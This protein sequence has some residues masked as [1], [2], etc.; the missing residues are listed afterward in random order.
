MNCPNCKEA[1]KKN[2]KDRTGEQKYKCLTCGSGFTTKPKLE[3]KRVPAAKIEMAIN[4]LV[5]GCSVRSV[6]RLTSIHRDTILRLL[7]TVGERCMMLQEKLVRNVVM[8]NLEMDEIW[9]YCLMKQKTA[10]AKGLEDNPEIGSVYTFTAIDRTSKLILAW[11]CGKRGETD[12]LT[13]LHKV[14]AAIN[15]D[16][17]FQVS[18]DS[19][20]GYTN[21]VPLVL[22][23]QAHYGQIRKFYGTPNPDEVRYSGGT[24]IAAIR[25]PMYGYPNKKDISTSIAERSNLTIRMQTKR[26]TRLGNAFSKKFANHRYALALFFFHYNFCRSHKSLNDCTP[27]MVAGLSTHIWDLKDLI[28]IK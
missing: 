12:T 24:C 7:E 16:E 1:S 11:H 25:K 13:F 6:E 15:P 3:G 4:M 28:G 27:A 2:G 26:L 5:E 19:F 17:Q 14:K 20:N 23:Q 8:Q 18:T 9:S 10:N 21:S 22:G